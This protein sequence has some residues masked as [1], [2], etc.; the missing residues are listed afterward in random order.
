[1]TGSMPDKPRPRVWSDC[2]TASVCHAQQQHEVPQQDCIKVGVYH[3]MY[4]PWLQTG[5]C[6]SGCWVS[7][8]PPGEP[9]ACMPPGAPM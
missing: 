8:C 6:T 5:G 1:M 3:T 4:L 2:S 7:P 9:T